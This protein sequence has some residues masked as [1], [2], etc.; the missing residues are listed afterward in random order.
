MLSACEK[1]VSGC[2]FCFAFVFLLS[3][4]LLVFGQ[5]VQWRLLKELFEVCQVLVLNRLLLKFFLIFSIL[6]RLS[7]LV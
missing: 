7:K 6:P 1:V 2:G 3:L 5:L 4:F